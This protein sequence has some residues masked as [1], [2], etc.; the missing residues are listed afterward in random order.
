MAPKWYSVVVE[1][2]DL[3]PG[4]AGGLT[5]ST[6]SWSLRL[7]TRRRSS[8][9]TRRTSGSRPRSGAWS[10][11]AWSSSQSQVV[12]R[13]EQ[14]SRAPGSDGFNF[15]SLMVGSWS[16]RQVLSAQF[17]ELGEMSFEHSDTVVGGLACREPLSLLVFPDRLE[18]AVEAGGLNAQLFVVHRRGVVGGTGHG[19]LLTGAK[20]PGPGGAAPPPAACGGFP[21]HLLPA[22]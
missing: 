6:G 8:L 11:R 18:R 4:P 13:A 7:M 17:G 15:G 19:C 14:E 20:G 10:G 21:R 12:E 22:H 16:A 3:Q 5:Y 2:D 1:C 9:N